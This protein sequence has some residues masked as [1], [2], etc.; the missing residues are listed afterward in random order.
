ME[1]HKE[2]VIGFDIMYVKSLPFAVSVSHALNLSTA[3]AIENRRAAI[4]LESIK[5]IKGTYARREFLMNTVLVDNEFAALDRPLAGVRDTLNVVALNKHVPEVERHIRTLK[6]RC[7]ATFNA[8]PFK[9]MPR[10]VVVELVYAMAFWLNAFPAHEGV[11]THINP[12]E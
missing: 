4:L 6:E 5:G 3:E 12:R 10:R 11:F 8:L 2:V 9:R 7:R 1:R